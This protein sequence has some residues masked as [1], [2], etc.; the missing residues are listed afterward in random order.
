MSAQ[1]CGHD[2]KTYWN[3][4][5]MRQAACEREE[6]IVSIHDGPCISGKFKI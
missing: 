2:G 3:E 4:C 5:L 6:A 1:I